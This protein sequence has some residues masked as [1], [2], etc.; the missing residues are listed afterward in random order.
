MEVVKDYFTRLNWVDIFFVICLIRTGYIGFSRGFTAEIS[1]NICA[2]LTVVLTYQFYGR[3]GLFLSKYPIVRAE[4]VDALAFILLVISFAA[5]SI[6]I[7]MGYRII[8]KASGP[9]MFEVM[10]GLIVGVARGILI[11]SLILVCVEFIAPGYVERSISEA[12]IVGQKLIKIA[13]GTYEFVSNLV[14]NG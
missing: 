13:P 5:V 1:R 8:M 6:L 3:L 9:H 10:G 14:K 11:S 7:C 2:F 12:S 4:A